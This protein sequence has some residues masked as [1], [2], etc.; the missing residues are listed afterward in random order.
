M[1]F[2]AAP[3]A[4]ETLARHHLDRWPNPDHREEFL[5]SQFARSFSFVAA[6]FISATLLSST[7]NAQQ[8]GTAVGRD[9]TA[10]SA[11]DITMPMRGTSIDSAPAAGP[12]VVRAGISAPMANNRPAPGSP[13]ND[14]HVGAGSNVAMMGVGAAGIVVGS[15][16][17]GNGGTMIAI[18][19]GVIG[20]IGLFRYLR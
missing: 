15:M 2:V 10:V 8:Q 11:G 5:M 20:L 19:G 16:I 7:L 1:S 4:P 18:G 12:R 3:G 13:L 17:G 6:V 14:A 9:S